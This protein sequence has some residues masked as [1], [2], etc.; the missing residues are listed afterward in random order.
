MLLFVAMGLTV[1]SIMATLIAA[2]YYTQY[3][4]TRKTV[5][6]FRSLVIKVN[7]LLDYG[8]GTQNWHNETAVGGSTVFEALLTS[9]KKVQY[10]TFSYGV[11]V[12]SI[13]G[14]ENS[15]TASSGYAW[16]WYWWNA[17]AS[18]W[19]NLEEGADACILKPNDSIAWRY[20]NYSY[21]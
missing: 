13:D 4:E 6:E 10:Q 7:V 14:V 9:T 21:G 20:E 8:N 11:L 19:T 16:F 17:T 15:G 18:R 3:I 1:W 2:Y 12:S 5:E